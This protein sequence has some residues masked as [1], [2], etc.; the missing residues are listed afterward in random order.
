MNSSQPTNWPEMW[1]PIDPVTAVQLQNELHREL[2]SQHPLFACRAE[3]LARR[4]DRDDVLFKI[5]GVIFEYAVVHL[6]WR[7]EACPEFPWTTFYVTM[8]DWQAASLVY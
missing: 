7:P 3:A 6:T 8:D 2:S 4:E 5:D 1:Q